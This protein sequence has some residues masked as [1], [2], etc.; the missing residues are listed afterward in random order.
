MRRQNF[1]VFWLLLPGF[2]IA[3]LFGQSLSLAAQLDDVRDVI[4]ATGKKWVA[5][6]TSVSQLPDH[7]KKLRLG[8]LKHARTGKEP[9]LALQEPLTGLPTSVDWRTY[10][11]PVRNQGSC[12]SCWAFAAAAALESNLLISDNRPGVNDDRAEEIL[13]SCSG[14]GSCAGGYIGQASD[15]I[16]G[17]G[18]PPESY[19]PYTAAGTDD[20]CGNA[21][22]GW[23]TA[24]RRIATWSYVNTAPA[25]VAAIKNALYTYGPL[26]TTMDVYYDFYYYSGGIYEYVSG[27]YQGG[28]AILIVGY[29]DDATVSGGG[30]FTVKNS[31]GAG[32]GSQ[33]YFYI[34]YSQVGS[35]VYFGEW[36]IAYTALASPSAPSGLTATAVA[37][38]Q[39]NLAWTDNSANED[40]FKVERCQGADCTSFEQVGTVGAGAASYANTGLTANTAYTYRVRAYNSVGDSGYSNTASAT[41]LQLPQSCSYSISPLNKSFGASQGTGA[42]SVTAGAGCAW[43]ATSNVSWIS[44]SAPASGTGS[45]SFSYRVSRN[46]G[47]SRTGTITVAGN[48][49]TVTQA[50]TGK[51]K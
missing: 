43:T 15:Y 4:R 12:G 20:T 2:M 3:S 22:A 37:S 32:W 23:Q 29:T 30:F 24:T 26:V 14:A 7:E 51:K 48:T 40:G 44:V 38:G 49:F 47:A 36:T 16:R 1:G 21:T 5:E 46:T 13:L 11:T 17:T 33:G 34:S 28:H 42:V 6:E 39:L 8:L 10:V 45:G 19:F 27:A 35:P 41:T 25:N 18:V 9:M 31:W 50:G